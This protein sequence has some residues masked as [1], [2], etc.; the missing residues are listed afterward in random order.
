MNCR[1]VDVQ[2]I[3]EHRILKR[4]NEYKVAGL[5]DP[6]NKD[7]PLS[8]REA[9]LG[10]EALGSLCCLKGIGLGCIDAGRSEKLLLFQIRSGPRVH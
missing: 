1:F 4:E 2:I 5:S 9:L 10:L 6:K 8:P 7:P 3:I